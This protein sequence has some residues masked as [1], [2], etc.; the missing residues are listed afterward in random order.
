MLC[1]ANANAPMICLTS[2]SV[3]TSWKCLGEQLEEIFLRFLCEISVIKS[4]MA[5]IS[6]QS[7]LT[8]A[9]PS[10]SFQTFADNIYHSIRRT[11]CRNPST[12]SSLS[13]AQSKQGTYCILPWDHM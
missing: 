8:E 12:K 1:A 10:Y 11:S 2:L 6:L 4:P 13:T 3:R 5:L 9:C 7:G